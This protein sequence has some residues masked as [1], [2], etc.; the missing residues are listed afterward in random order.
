MGNAASSC[1]WKSARLIDAVSEAGVA[2]LATGDAASG[3]NGGS[4]DVADG[5]AL[6]AGVAAAG[7]VATGVTVGAGVGDGGGVGVGEDD[8]PPHAAKT[9]SR[10]ISERSPMRLRLMAR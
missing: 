5:E 6:L 9:K 8:P 7:L 2:P 1:F 10:E 4:T 3:A